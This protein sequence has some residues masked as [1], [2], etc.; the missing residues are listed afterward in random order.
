MLV[1]TTPDSSERPWRVVLLHGIRS[2]GTMW[3][4]QVA[5]LRAQGHDVTAVDLPGHGEASGTPF[6][7]TTAQRTIQHVVENPR[8]R[9]QTWPIAV[10]G[11]SLGGYLAMHWAARTPSPPDLLVLSSS[12]AIPGGLLHRGY[13]GVT[14]LFGALGADGAEWVSNASARLA[15][16]REAAEDIGSGGIS[17]EGQKQA[18][19]A[20]REVDPIADLRCAVERDIP[21]AFIQGEWDHFRINERKF[22]EVAGP[23]ARWYHVRRAVHMVSS[24]RPRAYTA[25]FLRAL[26]TT[27]PQGQGPVESAGQ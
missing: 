1:T 20:M 4:P 15:L 21:I 17:V 24:H 10:G 26:E 7:L 19:A 27:R 13:Q 12:T 11:L 2:S 3:R 9:T 23:Q 16:G 5:A 22:R 6:T 14:E 25:A 18:L 8:P